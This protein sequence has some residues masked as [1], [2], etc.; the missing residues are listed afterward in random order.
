MRARLARVEVDRFAAGARG[1]DT[2][3][4]DDGP[5]VRAHRALDRAIGDPFELIARQIDADARRCAELPVAQEQIV[6]N[7]T[8]MEQLQEELRRQNE[9]YWQLFD[10]VPLPYVVTSSPSSASRP[11]AKEGV[12]YQRPAA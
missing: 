1:R 7:R 8:R 3:F 11:A 5:S 12:K 6:E 2:W 4:V 9:R 10:E